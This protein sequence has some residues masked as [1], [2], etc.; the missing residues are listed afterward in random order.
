M[1]RSAIIVALAVLLV[2]CTTSEREAQPAVQREGLFTGTGMLVDEATIY[3]EATAENGGGYSEICVGNVTSSTRRGF[4]RYTLPSIPAGAT[5][6][7]VQLSFTQEAVRR[8]GGGRLA[9]TLEVRAVTSSWTEGSGAGNTRSCGG[10]Q[11]VAGV[12]WN[13]MPSVAA[14]ASA[15]AVLPSTEPATIN[16]DSDNAAHAGL[17]TN[18]QSWV[19]G[20]TNHGWRLT[21]VEEAT[22]DNA[23]SIRPGALLVSYTLSNGSSCTVDSDCTSDSCV[24]PD[25]ADCDGA[26]GC[27]CCSAAVCNGACETCH[28]AGLVGTCAPRPAGIACRAAS[29]AD[30]VA[31]AAVSCNG[32]ARACPA[33]VET[34]CSPYACSGAACG[35]S[36]SGSS[37]CAGTNVCNTA[38]ACE[39]L[40]DECAQQLADCVAEATCDDPSVAAGDFICTCPSGYGGDGRSGGSS[41]IVICGDGMTGAG[42][43]CDDGVGNSDS[44]PDACRTDCTSARCGDGVIDTA[45]T[46]DPGDA[47]AGSELDDACTPQCIAAD[48]GAA[49]AGATDASVPDAGVS[50]GGTTDA[51]AADAGVADAGGSSGASGTGG[52]SG[53][54]SGG[55]GLSG[56]GGADM[57]DGAAAI[58]DAGDDV[59]PP[60]AASGCDCRT[61][62]SDN[63]LGSMLPA[64]AVLAVLFRRRRFSARRATPA[65]P[66]RGSGPRLRL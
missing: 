13:A 38:N 45:E 7:R 55:T 21:V 53:A 34:M 1:K 57:R 9:A 23:R 47:D 39:P 29:C 32:A 25:G 65:N 15:S 30:D 54:G 27:V 33:P 18:V 14:A 35:S 56:A 10:G 64:L 17:V 36:C 61:V 20:T 4:V 24:A 5:V 48:A 16:L 37:D 41:C 58:E 40:G 26:M 11:V 8:M 6:T 12:N 28:R 60:S 43:E 51:G 19:N 22:A 46:C 50:D 66:V 31:T 2:A 52:A 49:D 44:E 62:N 59:E 3:E 63:A 42:E